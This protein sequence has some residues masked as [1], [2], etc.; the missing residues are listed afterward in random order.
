[1]DSDEIVYDALDFFGLEKQSIVIIEEMA[2]LTKA[3]TKQHRA[4]GPFGFSDSMLEEC[5]D[6]HIM[7]R[8]MYYAMNDEDAR[9]YHAFYVQKLKR[10]AGIVG[11]DIEE[12]DGNA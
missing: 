8:Q 6:V 10:L 9:K 3:I 7:M 1:M 5:A 4:P 2:E 12:V 11:T